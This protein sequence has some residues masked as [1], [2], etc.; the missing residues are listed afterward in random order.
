MKFLCAI[1][2]CA[3]GF[4]VG[5]KVNASEWII[6][7]NC[8]SSSQFE[9]AA[10]ARH[11]SRAGWMVWAVANP[12]TEQFVWV[13]TVFTPD[14]QVIWSEPDSIDR[15]ADSQP[16]SRRIALA[17]FDSVPTSVMMVPSDR[18]IARSR[19]SSMDGGSG[20]ATILG[21]SPAETLQFQALVRISRDQVFFNPSD[22]LGYFDSFNSGY[23]EYPSALDAAIRTALTTANPAWNSGSLGA[24]GGLATALKS[25]FGRGPSAC[26]TFAN[27]DIGCFQV[28]ILAPGAVRY[29]GGTGFTATG[30]PID[31]VGIGDESGHVVVTPGAP[32][33]DEITYRVGGSVRFICGYA[34][35]Q[36]SECYWVQLP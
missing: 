19:I 15:G 6:C 18:E 16:K 5:G 1:I 12:N 36:L 8:V 4:F 2:I 11:G 3:S 33:A 23:N 20:S 35:G 21:A 34:M 27:G 14:G 28:N 31:A 10:Q 26:L 7:G 32:S 13:E 24:I 30:A 29:I 17:G 9:Y 22:S 25:Y